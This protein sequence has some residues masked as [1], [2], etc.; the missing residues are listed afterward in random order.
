MG[1][2]EGCSAQLVSLGRSH[3]TCSHQSRT[4]FF[5]QTILT[6]TDRGPRLR[7][8]CLL[9]GGH[10]ERMSALPV[11]ELVRAGGLGG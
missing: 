5:G 6:G 11:A 1:L 4:S 10:R 3:D 9:L 7:T 8:H 2:V